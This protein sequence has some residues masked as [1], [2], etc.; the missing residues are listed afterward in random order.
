MPIYVT[1]FS[2]TFGESIK[3]YIKTKKTKRVLANIIP[4]ILE[5]PFHKVEKVQGAVG[6][7][8]SVVFRRHVCGDAFRIFYSVDEKA[9]KI[10]FYC[11]RPKNKLTYK[12]NFD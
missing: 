4:K 8:G 7:R 11:V 2:Y 10:R 9:K 12:L 6:F 1:E 5:N 3:S